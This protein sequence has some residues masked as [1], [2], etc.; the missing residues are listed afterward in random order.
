MRQTIFLT[1]PFTLALTFA[2]HAAGS[3]DDTP[4]KPT[5]TTTECSD[6]Q[7]YDEST[8]SC[9]ESEEQS[10]NDDDRYDAVREL[11]Y[12]GAYSRAEKIMANA[13]RPDD[14]RFLNY[15]GFIARQQG[16]LPQALDFYM[17]ALAADPDYL[18]ARSY[19]GQGLAASG[20][21]AGAKEQLTEIAAR[22]G[23]NT[24]AYV[25]LKLALNGK[26]STY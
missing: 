16:N 23:R 17:E 5:R 26:P 9:V 20:D 14:P 10:F 6:G 19:M 13:E 24:W 12:A 4:P 18:L 11:A 25:S 22:G 7:I 3:D 8:K 15:R 21:L 1:I 2:V